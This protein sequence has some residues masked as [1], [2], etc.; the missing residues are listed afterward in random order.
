MKNNILR[1]I[2]KINTSTFVSSK[3]KLSLKEVLTLVFNNIYNKDQ[4]DDIKDTFLNNLFNEL[5]D[6]IEYDRVVCDT[7]I[8]NR[9]VNSIN[10]LDPDVNIKSYDSLNDEIMNKCIAIRNNLSDE[11][12]DND[13]LFKNKI[14]SEMKI[15][16]V[17]SNLLSQDQLNDILNIWIDHI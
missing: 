15:D 7:G 17:D 5:N 11:E 13:D 14:R 12:S 1:V 3:D 16:Y 2:N 6:C 8:Y 4:D 9:I 10:L